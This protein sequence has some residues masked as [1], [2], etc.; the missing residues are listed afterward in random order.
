ISAQSNQ[1][2]QI[3]R[4]CHWWQFGLCDESKNVEGLPPE[5]PRQGT[6]ITI[7][8]ATNN[9]YLFKDSQLIVKSPAATGSEKLLK[10]R[11]RVWLFRTPHG[12]FKVL[13]KI[14]DPIWRKPD[15]AFV[16]AGEAVPPRYSPKRDV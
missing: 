11:G 8:V 16:E 7:D 12:H 9:L 4:K 10:H 13:Q 1:T 6:V 14:E 15:W 2:Q 5:A 3:S